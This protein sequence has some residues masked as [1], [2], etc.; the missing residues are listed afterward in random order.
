MTNTNKVV[1]NFSDIFSTLD[2]FNVWWEFFICSFLFWS[3]FLWQPAEPEMNSDQHGESE[4]KA[5]MILCHKSFG[6]CLTLKET[7]ESGDNYDFVFL[8][9][10]RVL[11]KRRQL[12]DTWLQLIVSISGTSQRNELRNK[13]EK[14][15]NTRVGLSTFATKQT[16][17]ISCYVDMFLLEICCCPPVRFF[18]SAAFHTLTLVD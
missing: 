10:R 18:H 15:S 5:R 9:A 17:N 8:F 4:A 6:S 2:A 14:R 1:H 11:I 12:C 3:I 16:K 13:T 7:A